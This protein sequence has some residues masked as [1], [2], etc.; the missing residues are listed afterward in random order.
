M[1]S[2]IAKGE[3][4]YWMAEKLDPKEVVSIA[5]DLQPGQYGLDLFHSTLR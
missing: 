5:V 4:A 2:L 3:E 1:K